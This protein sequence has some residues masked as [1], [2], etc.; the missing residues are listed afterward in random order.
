MIQSNPTDLFTMNKNWFNSYFQTPKTHVAPRTAHLEKAVSKLPERIGNPPETRLSDEKQVY[1][2]K[3]IVVIV[4]GD[5]REANEITKDYE[6][7]TVI[8]KNDELKNFQAFVPVNKQFNVRRPK[9]IKARANYPKEISSNDSIRSSKHTLQCD[10]L[11]SNLALTYV[12]SPIIPEEEK[13]MKKKKIKQFFK[14][15]FRIK[16]DPED[17]QADNVEEEIILAETMS[18][19]KEHFLISY[20]AEW[21]KFKYLSEV[22]AIY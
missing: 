15:I 16:E 4:V 7:A 14:K 21:E 20:R 22:V 18:L 3:A 12:T 19:W 10:R 13:D 11:T 8:M 5:Q 17:P 9:P 6:H 2:E 1:S